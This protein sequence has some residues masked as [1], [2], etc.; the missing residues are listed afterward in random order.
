MRKLHGVL[1]VMGL[2]ILGILF[3]NNVAFADETPPRATATAI[4][5]VTPIT[6]VTNTVGTLGVVTLNTGWNL[7]SIPNSITTH[8]ASS[9]L[10][11]MNS[12][13][14]STTHISKWEN[15]S[16]SSHVSHLPTNNFPI[17]VGKGYFVKVGRAGQ[18]HP[19]GETVQELRA[20]IEKIQ[21]TAFGD[22]AFMAVQ[23]SAIDYINEMMYVRGNTTLDNTDKIIL[24]YYFKYF[25]E[26]LNYSSD[27]NSMRRSWINHKLTELENRYTDQNSQQFLQQFRTT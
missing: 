26:A 22:Y 12:Q 10:V 23:A 24:G 17:E 3:S 20:R 16:W 18:W 25:L 21:T 27:L 7:I 8:S 9:L 15:G 1:M 14:L 11:E 4:P 13:G 5:T 6:T 2:I 19:G